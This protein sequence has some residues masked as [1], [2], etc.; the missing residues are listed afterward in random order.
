MYVSRIDNDNEIDFSD[1]DIYTVNGFKWG[2]SLLFPVKRSEIKILIVESFPDKK[3]RMFLDKDQWEM[4]IHNSWVESEFIL[5]FQVI[6]KNWS[7]KN[8]FGNYQFARI[9]SSLE[10]LPIKSEMIGIYGFDI[11]IFENDEFTMA[12][13]GKIGY[14]YDIIKKQVANFIYQVIM[15]KEQNFYKGK[16][17]L[18][19][20][21]IDKWFKI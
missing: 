9:V 21:D 2:E 19:L 1:A 18:L 7:I 4:V 12:R 5:S 10:E 3:E 6:N 15:K 11:T 8:E 13:L 16:Y 17:E 14:S 20:D